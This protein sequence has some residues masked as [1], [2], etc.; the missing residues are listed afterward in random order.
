MPLGSSPA[1]RGRGSGRSLVEAADRVRRGPMTGLALHTV[2]LQTVAVQS[3]ALD[4]DVPEDVR[5][6]RIDFDFGRDLA[7]PLFAVLSAEERAIAAGF[8]HPADG[9]RSAVTRAALRILLGAELGVAPDSLGFVRSERGRPALARSDL[10]F[11][12][13]HSGDHA[14]IALSRRRRVGVDVELRRVDWDWS[15]LGRLALGVEDRRHVDAEH[16]ATWRADVFYAVW[17]AKE[18]LLKAEGSGIAAGLETFWFSPTIPAVPGSPARARSRRVLRPIGRPGSAAFPGT[19]PAWPGER[20]R[21]IEGRR[22]GALPPRQLVYTSRCRWPDRRCPARGSRASA[23][24]PGP[25][26]L[27]SAWRRS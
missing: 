6:V 13:S 4:A 5:L 22:A 17:T 14:L 20:R 11:N 18:A 2:A 15:P 24:S 19:R 9:L 3:V 23:S 25:L 26:R 7:D 21:G 10:D 12:V 1:E 8:R 16:Q 27:P